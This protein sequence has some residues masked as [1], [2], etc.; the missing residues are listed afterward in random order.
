MAI[1]TSAIVGGLIGLGG[2]NLMAYMAKNANSPYDERDFT[3]SDD[4]LGKVDTWAAAN[5]YKLLSDD[6]KRRVYSKGMNILT[7]PMRLEVLRDGDRYTTRS[8]VHINALIL[9]GDLALSYPGFMAK[10]P[11]ASARKAQNQLF[12]DLGQPPLS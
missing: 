4:V 10:V 6:G 3:S 8:Y 5:G 11:R 2:L 9:T 12:A 7:A 1:I